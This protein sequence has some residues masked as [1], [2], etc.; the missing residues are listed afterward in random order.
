MLFIE[1][2]VVVTSFHKFAK[3][4]RQDMFVVRFI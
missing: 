4:R 3:N 1:M 2:I